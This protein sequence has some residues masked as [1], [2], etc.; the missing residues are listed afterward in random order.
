[1]VVPPP[2]P[3]TCDGGGGDRAIADAHRGECAADLELS[4]PAAETVLGSVP[5][6]RRWQDGSGDERHGVALANLLGALP[7]GP[8]ERGEALSARATVSA[9]GGSLGCPVASLLCP[10]HEHTG[11]MDVNVQCLGAGHQRSREEGDAHK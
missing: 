8:P 7:L 11:G 10:P 1:M 6:R 9:D 5:S 2:P 4:P 3:S